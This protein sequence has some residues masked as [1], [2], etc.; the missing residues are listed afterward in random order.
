MD[1]R[2][3]GGSTGKTPCVMKRLAVVLTVVAV[4]AACGSG[5]DSGNDQNSEG[6][7]RVGMPTEVVAALGSR[8]VVLSSEDG[9]IVRTL[10][11]GQA[12]IRSA[13]VSPD[14]TTV[15]FTRT[16]PAAVCGQGEAFQI[17][18]VPF[19][20]GSPTIFASGWHAVVS[21][22][23]ERIAYATGGANQC[24]PLNQLA[25]QELATDDFS[26][27][28]FE[29][30][31]ATLVPL[32]WSPDSRRVLY[33]AQLPEEVEAREVEPGSG[34]PPR[35]VPLPDGA[36]LPTYL[37]NA[38]SLA[39]VEDDGE[40]A[41]IL[42]VDASTGEVQGSLFEL[43]G[44]PAFRSNT[45]D[46]SGRHLLFTTLAGSS[47]GD[48]LWRWSDAERDPVVLL[49]TSNGETAEDATWVPSANGG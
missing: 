7:E 28:L 19:E 44:R 5:G 31:D 10:V 41:R 1:E 35:A 36:Y 49:E 26:Q 6:D 8:L 13:A 33:S 21:P 30:G 24:G 3:S 17:V 16:D 48:N 46:R 23:G 4:V 29:G 9:S 14:G 38:D 12:G 32:A 22:D 47:G 37:G 34:A 2:A 43:D 11:D 18:T 15:Y 25:V 20:G 40:Q 39:V 45:A 27:E 42:E